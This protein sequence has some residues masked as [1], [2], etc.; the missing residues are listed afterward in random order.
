AGKRSL[1]VSSIS[2]TSSI[3]SEETSDIP[4]PPLIPVSIDPPP[5]PAQ[6]K[7]P[8]RARTDRQMQIEQ[9][10]IELQG[11]FITAGGSVEEKIHMRAELQKRIEKIRDLSESEWAYG[12]EG[13]VPEHLIG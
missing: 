3:G 11:R 9:K 6:L 1:A 4:I 10:I 12:G 5:S 13:G 7:A 2:G 8:S